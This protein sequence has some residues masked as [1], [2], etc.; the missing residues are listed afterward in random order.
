MKNLILALTC[1]F[2]VLLGGRSFAAG[3][4]KDFSDFK[5]I[6]VLESGRLKPLDT[7]ARSLLTQFSGK[8]HYQ[9]Q[10][11]SAWLASL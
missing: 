3:Q 6:P 1:V 11:A 9:K 2:L 8:D 10:E 7:F 5:R 4:I